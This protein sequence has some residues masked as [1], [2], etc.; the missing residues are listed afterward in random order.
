MPLVELGGM[1]TLDLVSIGSALISSQ[2]FFHRRLRLLNFETDYL[3]SDIISQTLVTNSTPNSLL[4]L[5]TMF[6]W[7]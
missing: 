2:S 6:R 5:K 7:A 3:F 1:I 4:S